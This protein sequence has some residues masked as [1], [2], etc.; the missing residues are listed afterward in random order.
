MGTGDGCGRKK[1]KAQIALFPTLDATDSRR[2]VEWMAGNNAKPLVPERCEH[3]MD[4]ER[5]ILIGYRGAGKTTVGRRMASELGWE[6]A[7]SDDAIE[8]AAGKSVAEIFADEGEESFRAREA[9][10]LREL[11]GRRRIVLA[12][13][14]GA[15][16]RPTNREL[17]RTAGFTIWLKARPETIWARLQSD[18]TTAGRRP[19]LTPAGG[20][21]EVRALVA[22]RESLYRMIA[23][24]IVDADVPSPE[25]VVATILKA[26]HGFRSS[27][28]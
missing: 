1:I 13:G 7:D 27:R 23:D 9:E 26:W 5:I 24:F 15:V 12:T 19:N 16:L 6:F 2:F 22:A 4:R 14:G 17:L 3:D 10:A 11:C 18:P 28:S 25:S 21:D 20:V 8:A